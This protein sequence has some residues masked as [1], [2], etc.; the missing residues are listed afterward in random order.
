MLMH[1]SLAC[2]ETFRIDGS[3]WIQQIRLNCIK[4]YILER[5]RRCSVRGKHYPTTAGWTYTSVMLM[6][7]WS[8]RWLAFTSVRF[9]LW[10]RG[11]WPVSQLISLSLC[12]C[13]FTIR[14]DEMSAQISRQTLD[15]HIYNQ[16]LSITKRTTKSL[17]RGHGEE[18]FMSCLS[19]RHSW[20][21]L[22]LLYY[23]YTSFRVG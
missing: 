6:G 13:V 8:D 11:T 21:Q 17:I 15:I 22:F 3:D 5:K 23:K 20:P 2:R 9:C 18:R 1:M 10:T 12:V 4:K 19:T 16:P 14:C 7:N